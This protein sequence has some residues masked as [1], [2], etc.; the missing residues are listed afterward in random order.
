MLKPI[1]PIALIAVLL[2]ASPMI[3]P[4]ASASAQ[5]QDSIKLLGVSRSANTI[6]A[7]L[8]VNGTQLTTAATV[9][10]SGTDSTVHWEGSTLTYPTYI[11]NTPYSWWTGISNPPELYVYIS[12]S[13]AINGQTGAEAVVC[14]H[15]AASSDEERRITMPRRGDLV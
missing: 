1:I 6:T 11:G 15:D 14:T 9:T 13:S 10:T 8:M 4:L 2:L 7:T 5:T 12:P 3:V